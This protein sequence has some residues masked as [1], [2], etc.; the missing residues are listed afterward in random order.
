MAQADDTE[1]QAPNI[2]RY[3]QEELPVPGNTQELLPPQ[4][5]EDLDK[6]GGVD[7]GQANDEIQVEEER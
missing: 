2:Q 3:S 6:G 4:P 7:K 5:D 1:Q